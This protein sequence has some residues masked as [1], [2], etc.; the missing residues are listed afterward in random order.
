MAD[1]RLHIFGV[2]HHGP[3]S[4]ASLVAALDEL[5]PERVLIEGPPEGDE[6]IRFAA[7]KDMKP[8]VALLIHAANDPSLA[9]FY[10]YADYSPEWQAMRWALK[11]ERPVAFMDL[12]VAHKLA[13]AELGREEDKALEGKAEDKAGDAAAQ[14]RLETGT[15]TVPETPVRGD[16]MGVLAELAGY[17]DS[18]AWWNALIEQSPHRPGVFT[19][20]ETALT[21]LR[22][23]CDSDPS[24]AS[25]RR[26]EDDRREAFMRLA[27][28]D[29][30]KETSGPVAIITGAWH[31]PALRRKVKRADDR[32]ML[33]KLPKQKVTATWVPWTDTRLAA[34]SGYGAGVISPGWYRH[35]WTHWHSRPSGDAPS[36]RMLT[37]GWQSRIARL[38]REN[39][40]QVD[41]AS[42]IEA[43]RLAETL[44]SMRVLSVPGLSEMREAC[45]A[46]LCGGET[47]PLQLIEDQLV[48]GG[49]VGTIDEAVPQMPLQADL[50]RQQKRVKLKPEGLDR[51]LAVDLRSEAG[52]AKSLLLHRLTILGI[53]WGRIME[54]NHSRG[55]FRERWMLCWEPE[56]SVRLAE[57]LIYGTTLQQAS[58]NCAFAKA[59][60]AASLQ[61]L[62]Q[63]IEQCLL[64]GLDQAARSAISLLQQRSSQ[65]NDIAGLL[66]SVP[67]LANILRYGTA[68]EI[69]ESELRL[70]VLSMAEAICAG[71]MHSCRRLEDAPAEEMRSQLAEFGR[72]SDLL[73]DEALAEN[74]RA[75]L[76]RLT[77]E[78]DVAPVLQGFAA[79]TLYDRSALPQ[80]V[81]ALRVS[82]AL[83]PANPPLKAGKWLDGFL[84]GGG[85]IL[86]HDAQLLAILDGWMARQTEEAFTNM[87]PM[88]RMVFSG[89]DKTERRHL[90]DRVR[91]PV[92]AAERQP[93]S[94]AANRDAPGFEAALP[95]LFTILGLDETKEPAHE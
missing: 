53:P 72:A 87:L 37:A 2:R 55:T 36:I 81:I 32:A 28:A 8:P 38:L 82:R 79:R 19:A 47:V 70:L 50:A 3:G 94:D 16:P 21:A 9:A 60:D 20:L 61:E 46:T 74:W 71:L 35:L 85:Q 14:D 27:I 49:E 57:A 91:Q 42:V 13:L 1:E 40:R 39:G 64:A 5:L 18:E 88:L 77:E 83:S 52:L 31:V 43:A 29:A 56:F 10:P 26:E 34:I 45:L 69:P 6:L 62:S 80:E 66:T 68:R 44:A 75:A 25:S 41:T 17:D 23:H 84:T 30:L 76:S 93:Q 48:I 33:R 59:R 11:H 95:M 7:S 65:S 63:A 54:A 73:G 67:P 15:G 22:E 92:S 58:N 78:E 51:E 24:F 89:L 12:P 86:L 90:L 4:A